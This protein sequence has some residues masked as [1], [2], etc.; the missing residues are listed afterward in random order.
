MPKMKTVTVGQVQAAHGVHGELKIKPLCDDPKRFDDLDEIMLAHKE[1]VEKYTIRSCRYHKG[2]V[3]LQ[4]DGLE[5]RN[6]A[7][8]VKGYDC[9]IPFDQRRPLPP[10]R[11]YIDDLIGLSVYED[12]ICLGE[13]REVLQPGANDVYVV[14]GT[15]GKTIYV[16]ALKTVV[17]RVDLAAGQMD[18]QL[19]AGLRDE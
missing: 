15:D 2:S 19:P 9:L 12:G 14:H 11:F 5:D 4:L 6:A 10:D 13:I 17:N 8:A 7:E 1:M 18:V 3:L 16:P